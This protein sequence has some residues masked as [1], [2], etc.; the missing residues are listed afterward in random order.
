MVKVP[1]VYY[2]EFGYR[3]LFDIWRLGFGTYANKA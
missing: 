2:L 3:N 1:I